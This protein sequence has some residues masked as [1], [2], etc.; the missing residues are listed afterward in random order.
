[1]QKETHKKTYAQ[2]C[3]SATVLP[4]EFCTFS[5]IHLILCRSCCSVYRVSISI[6]SFFFSAP[7]KCVSFVFWFCTFY[8]TIKLILCD[9]MREWE[10]KKWSKLGHFAA[11]PTD[12]C[13]NNRLFSQF[14]PLICLWAS[15][16]EIIFNMRILRKL[17]N[18]EDVDAVSTFAVSIG[19]LSD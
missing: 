12:I 6:V 10:Q 11:M 8:Q 7:T 14:N 13:D 16:I 4:P 15:I 9:S 1:M 2:K 19:F 17:L 3:V 18:S 5:I